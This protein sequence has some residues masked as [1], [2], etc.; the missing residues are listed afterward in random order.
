MHMKRSLI[1]VCL[2]A[3]AI[4]LTTF[5]Q[6]THTIHVKR[7]INAPAAVVWKAAAKDYGEVSNWHRY[8]YT[9]NYVEGSL[10]G[11]KGARRMCNFNEKGTR[12]LKEEIGSVDDKN[13]VMKN[14][15]IG[16]AKFPMDTENSYAY[17]RVTDNG[18]NTATLSYELV[19][20][21]KPAFMG[22]LAK[23]KF[24]RM[25]NELQIGVEHYVTTGE[26]L[27]ATTGNWKDVKKKYKKE[28][29]YKGDYSE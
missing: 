1:L 16:A 27:N 15:I 13:M 2:L 24:K 28:G 7:V 9:S 10:I 5:G 26:I 20:R 23:G 25:L 8:L 18:D 22:G 17:T 21:T 19:Y 3:L 6:K 11:V 4:P 29:K 12:W 14:L